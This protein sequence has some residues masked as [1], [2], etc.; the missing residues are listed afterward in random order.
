LCDILAER[1]LPIAERKQAVH[2]IGQVGFLD[3]LPTLERLATRLEARLTGQQSMAFAGSG[4]M[5]EEAELL[6]AITRAIGLLK[7][8]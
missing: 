8:P 4:G 2:F 1:Q 5:A 6:P 7:A 3:A